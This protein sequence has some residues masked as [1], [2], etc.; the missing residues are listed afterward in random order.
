[1]LNILNRSLPLPFAV[2]TVFLLTELEEDAS[3]KAVG[4]NIADDGERGWADVLDMFVGAELAFDIPLIDEPAIETGEQ[5]L[6][7]V[8]SG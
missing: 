2:K 7:V 6:N 8:V 1:M 5:M 4:D 3:A